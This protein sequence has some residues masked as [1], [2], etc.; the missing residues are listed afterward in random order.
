MLNQFTANATGLPVVVG[1]VEATV[2]GNAIVQLIALGEI[3]NLEQGRAV[4]A[5][6]SELEHYEPAETADWQAA[7]G[8]FSD[9]L[10]PGF[11]GQT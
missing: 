7:Y 10:T 11:D 4:V 6:M 2:I 8:R 1:P 5:G 9:L 3:E